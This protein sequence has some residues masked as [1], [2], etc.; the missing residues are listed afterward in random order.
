M[1]DKTKAV[2]ENTAAPMAS[3][4]EP[5]DTTEAP[6]HETPK[7][8][9]SRRVKGARFVG[10]AWIAEDGTPLTNAEAQQAHRAMDRAAAEARERALR[11]ETP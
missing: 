9:M 3:A 11:G 7:Q 8:A 1:A 2:V 5:I 4:A 6:A 10:G